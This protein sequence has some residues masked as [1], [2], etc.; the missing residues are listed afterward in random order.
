MKED[1]DLI[2]SVVEALKEVDMGN[3]TWQVAA[4]ENGIHFLYFQISAKHPKLMGEGHGKVEIHYQGRAFPNAIRNI[5]S[6]HRTNDPGVVAL[7][8]V[9]MGIL[10]NAEH[11][12]A[13]HATYK[14]RYIANPH[15]INTEERRDCWMWYGWDPQGYN[16]MVQHVQ[17]ADYSYAELPDHNYWLDHYGR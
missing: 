1:S 4:A 11:E 5:M 16:H 12:F 14:G 6:R 9:R 3:C 2:Q 10:A 15:N 17:Q 8:L 13:E 7:E